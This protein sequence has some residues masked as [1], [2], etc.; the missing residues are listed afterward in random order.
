MRLEPGR[1]LQRWRIDLKKIARGKK[2]PDRGD[3]A[4]ARFEIGNAA[5]ETTAVPPGCAHFQVAV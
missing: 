2:A 5:G 3:D 1:D 4:G